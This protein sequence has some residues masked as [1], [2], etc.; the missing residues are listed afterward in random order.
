MR[1]LLDRVPSIKLKLGGLIVVAL[2]IG[3]GVSAIGTG[4]GW[5]PV[6]APVVAVAVGLG[7]IQVLARGMTAPLR[8]M[9]TAADE[10]RRGRYDQRVVA[11]GSDEVGRLATAFNDMAA[12]LSK[13]DRL[14]RDLIANAAHELRTP[15]AGLRATID[16]MV[17]G[18]TPANPRTLVAMGSQV[19][20]LGALVDQL[21]D[22]SRLESGA[23]PLSIGPMDLTA[24]TQQAAHDLR[25]L[26]AQREADV[27]VESDTDDAAMTGDEVRLRQV[28]V[29]LIGNALAHSPDGARVRVSVSAPAADRLRLVVHDDGPGIPP[30]E[31]GRVFERF[32]R[33]DHA[34]RSGHGAGLGLAI[35]RWI[36]DLHGGRIVHD[37]DA[38]GCRMVVD[39]PRTPPA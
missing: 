21:M 25:G 18:I 31:A 3:A 12:E 15:I 1:P 7:V 27:V 14:R 2:V 4:L 35:C 32:Y 34:R 8:Q 22:L 6:L 26:A 11:T 20:R 28:G 38:P 9:A 17:D 33:A 10:L 36:V 19:A 24:V 30:D 23:A 16:N 37:P 29:N 5:H 13:V 39:L